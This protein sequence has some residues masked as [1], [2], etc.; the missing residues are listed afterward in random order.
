LPQLQQTKIVF[1]L[2]PACSRSVSPTQLSRQNYPQEPGRCTYLTERNIF[3]GNVSR[4]GDRT[5]D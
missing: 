4:V 1:G 5:C 2:P 3:K